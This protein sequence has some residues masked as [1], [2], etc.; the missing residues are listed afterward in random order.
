[1]G[2][3]R[4]LGA[5]NCAGDIL[6]G[7]GACSVPRAAMKGLAL[8]LLLSA[9]PARAVVPFLEPRALLSTQLRQKPE[10]V[11]ALSSWAPWAPA[12]S[13]SS[14]AAPTDAA[15]AS[16]V[17]GDKRLKSQGYSYA[18]ENW[19]GE[20]SSSSSPASFASF[21]EEASEAFAAAFP[22]PST[23]LGAAPQRTESRESDG[24]SYAPG[25]WRK[26]GSSASA[27]AF[28]SSTKT[29]IKFVLR[30]VLRRFRFFL[31]FWSERTAL[32]CALLAN[33]SPQ[34][35]PRT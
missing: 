22:S 12:S 1:M 26:D 30:H 35:F 34:L 6:S 19:G 16:A 18:P 4:T 21:D 23:P 28:V 5:K 17:G 24:R 20:S 14:S 27:A 32:R 29:S 3:D 13:S 9:D 11:T 31:S 7:K 10:S 15:P 2:D 33:S 8:A 25:S